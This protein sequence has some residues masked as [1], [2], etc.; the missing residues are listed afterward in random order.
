[1]MPKV[2]ATKLITPLIDAFKVISSEWREFM[3]IGLAAYLQSQTEK[4]YLTNTFL[5]RTEKVV[6]DN[7]YFPIKAYY[8]EL[9]TDFS[10]L[11]D[12]LDEYNSIALI[13][14]AGSGKTMLIKYIFLQAIRLRQRIPILIELRKMNDIDEELE[15]IIFNKILKTGLKP[16]E[17]IL[18]R[19]LH[20]GKFLFLFDGYDE[21]FSTRKSK[22]NR[23]IEEFIDNYSLNKF[24]ITTRPGSGIEGFDR[25]YNFNVLPLFVHEITNFVVKMVDDVERRK[26]IVSVVDNPLDRAYTEFLK[27]PLLLSMFI[28]AFESHP[29]I[30]GRKSVFYRNV[31]DTLYSKHDGITKSSFPREKLT[32]LQIHDFENVLATFSY[33]TLMNGKFTFTYEYLLDNLREVKEY[34]E[35]EYEPHSMIQDLQTAISIIVLDGFEYSFPHRSI[36]EYFAALFISRLETENKGEAYHNL[37]NILREASADNSRNL[38]SL[39][40]EL[41]EKAF[42]I[43]FI[44]PNLKSIL[45]ELSNKEG[46]ELILSY[47]FLVGANLYAAGE[48]QPFRIYRKDTFSIAVLE[49]CETS[50]YQNIWSFPT[51]SGC[52]AAL[53]MIEPDI[54]GQSHNPKGSR[55]LTIKSDVMQ[56]LL[57]YGL[58]EVIAEIRMGIAL[59]IEEFELKIAQR[60]NSINNLLAKRRDN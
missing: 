43:N 5:H 35:K 16:N 4:Y 38:W 18:Q 50:N 60:Q 32:G 20:D 7:I 21:I 40:M 55:G 49:F 57:K 14:L 51:I 13:G 56:V 28:L 11:E 31:F 1:M 29:E 44:L 46:Q 52:N 25:F 27:N 23:Q 9:V 34:L 19:T 26:R 33:I 53:N 22:I 6:F 42:V 47:F 30:P 39:C 24:I 12:V 17:R 48:K 54:L 36:Q 2:E 8:G 15:K 37:L 59:R 10:K 58:D 3:E 41:D 45:T